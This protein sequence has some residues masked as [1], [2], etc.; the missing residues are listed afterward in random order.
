MSATILLRSLQI[1]EDACRLLIK[2]PAQMH[3]VYQRVEEVGWRACTY[4]VEVEPG[5]KPRPVLGVIHLGEQRRGQVL[6]ACRAV[7]AHCRVSSVAVAA[8]YG[9]GLIGT[10]KLLRVL[11][12]GREAATGRAAN[13]AGDR[14]LS[15][16]KP[17]EIEICPVVVVERGPL[18]LDTLHER[19]VG[20]VR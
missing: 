17:A 14:L 5:D 12:G 18:V 10:H 16:R 15:E 3:S 4:L 8:R 2:Q 20:R 1:A 9:S 6:M 11:G 13:C 7:A 19:R